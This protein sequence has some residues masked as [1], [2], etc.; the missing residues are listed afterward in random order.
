VAKPYDFGRV[1]LDTLKRRLTSDGLEDILLQAG[2]DPWSLLIANYS[3]GA[4]GK[5]PE[6]LQYMA[7]LSARAGRPCSQPPHSTHLAMSAGKRC[8]ACLQQSTLALHYRDFCCACRT[9]RM[10]THLRSSHLRK[11]LR[12]ASMTRISGG[13]PRSSAACSLH[14]RSRRTRGRCAPVRARNCVG[15]RSTFIAT[16]GDSEMK[17]CAELWLTQSEVEQLLD[18]GFMPLISI[19]GSDSIRVARIQS[20][21]PNAKPLAGRWNS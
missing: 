21:A 5:D 17:P 8:G 20:I 2:D 6:L 14:N 18:E 7:A 12:A 4:D 10:P 3:F 11:C 13:T 1:E 16:N 19:R 9:A 15:F